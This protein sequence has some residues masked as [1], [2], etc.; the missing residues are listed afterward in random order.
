MPYN[1]CLWKLCFQIVI[2]CGPLTDP[3]N[4]RVYTSPGTIFGNIATYT[5]D[6]GYTLS[7]SQSRSCGADGNWTFSEPLCER[8]Y[9]LATNQ[10][11]CSLLVFTAVDRDPLTD[12]TKGQV[13]IS[14]GTTFGS[15]AT[16][17]CNTGY[18]LSH[19]Q[20][21]MCGADGVWSPASPSCIS[22]LIVIYDWTKKLLYYFY[23]F[24]FIKLLTVVTFLIQMM[25][26]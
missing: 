20:V 3:D 24:F 7:G 6:T 26:K 21:V 16:F 13:D 11:L 9:V 22:E 18:R 19:Q 2:D 10:F 4:G 8:K 15:V 14:S 23:A 1:Y 12:P 25:D 17:S 5:C